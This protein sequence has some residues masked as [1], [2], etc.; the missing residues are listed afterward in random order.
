MCNRCF[1]SRSATG[2]ALFHC[3]NTVPKERFENGLSD[4]IKR[5]QVC[6]SE[7]STMYF[8]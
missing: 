4:W 7:C 2:N 1:K 3:I 6:A 5:L 8:E